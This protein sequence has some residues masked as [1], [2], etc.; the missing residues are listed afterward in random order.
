MSSISQ[1][2]SSPSYDAG[3]IIHV[4]SESKTQDTRSSVEDNVGV[5]DKVSDDR[6]NI[7]IFSAVFLIFNRMVGTGIFSITSTILKLSGSVGLSMFMWIAG[8]L[9]AA[10]GM[11]VYVEFGTAIPR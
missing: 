2:T 3:D 1:E 7:G 10:A 6:R 4:R 5:F 11:L 8:M 9:I